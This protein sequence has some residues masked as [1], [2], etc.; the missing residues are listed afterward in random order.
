MS[1]DNSCSACGCV[2]FHSLSCPRVD[3]DALH[4]QHDRANE[5]LSLFNELYTFKWLGACV[6]WDNA[7]RAVR[8]EIMQRIEE[9]G[10]NIH[11]PEDNKPYITP[12]VCLGNAGDVY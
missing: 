9:I 10:F 1:V 6:G 5:L 7:I 2:G 12:K 4:S 11:I 3:K 8:V